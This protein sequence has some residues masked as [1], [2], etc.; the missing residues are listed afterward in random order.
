VV[1]AFEAMTED[2]PY[3]KALTRVE[4]YAALRRNSGSQFDSKVVDAFFQ[5][6][7]ED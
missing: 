4:A 5:I 1:D 2:C 6:M 7:P 3:R